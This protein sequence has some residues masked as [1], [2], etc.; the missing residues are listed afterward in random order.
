MRILGKTFFEKRLF[1]C[2]FYEAAALH[3]KLYMGKDMG[4]IINLKETF[5]TEEGYAV[6]AAC[7]FEPTWEKFRERADKLTKDSD[8]RMFGYAKNDT[9]IGVIVVRKIGDGAEICGIAVNEAER[10]QGIGGKLVR[11]ILEELHFDVLYAET[12][13]DAVGFYRNVGFVTEEFMKTYDS[14]V[15]RRYR[16]TLRKG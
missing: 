1:P 4:E 7:M 6:Y 9:V 14:G 2:D 8:V 5:V 13:D 12:D 11:Y 3:K 16:C 15:Y 10:G